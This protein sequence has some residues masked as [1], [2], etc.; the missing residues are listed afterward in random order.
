MY[1]DIVVVAFLMLILV[2]WL[3]LIWAMAGGFKSRGRKTPKRC[4][5]GLNR[6]EYGCQA[7]NDAANDYNQGVS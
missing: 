3:T 4:H 5:L 2:G 7:C 6:N 1:F